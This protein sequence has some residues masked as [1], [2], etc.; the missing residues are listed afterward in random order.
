[1]VEVIVGKPSKGNIIGPFIIIGAVAGIF[2]YK[3]L[4]ISLHI[5]QNV[6]LA[7][8]ITAVFV[9]ASFVLGLAIVKRRLAHLDA[10]LSKARI[11]DDGIYLQE[12]VDYETGVYSAK[13]YWSSSGRNRTYRVYSKFQ[14]NEKGK[15]SRVPLPS[16][17]FV[18]SVKRDDEGYISA[19]AVKLGGKYE[20]VIVMVLE[21]RGAVRGSGTLT[22][23]YGDDY[24]TLNFEGKGNILEGKVSSFIRKAR[25]SKVELYHEDYPS[26]RFKIAEGLN[27]AF[28]FNPFRWLKPGEKTVIVTL[29]DFSPKDFRRLFGMGEYLMGHGKYGIRLVIDV[30]MHRDIGKEAHFEVVLVNSRDHEE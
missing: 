21:P 3:G 12:E 20:G 28:S 5:S 8:G 18:V 26:N 22:V 10:F 11:E 4:E 6:L 25:K 19:P 17:K 23:T 15:A 29:Q 30:P 7:L 16:G 9:V 2:V 1:M 13:G 27:Y 24:A 14:E